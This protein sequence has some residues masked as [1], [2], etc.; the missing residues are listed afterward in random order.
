MRILN[1]AGTGP[2]S[3]LADNEDISYKNSVTRCGSQHQTKGQ[4]AKLQ[5]YTVHDVQ[6]KKY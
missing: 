4:Q 3:L 1:I 5:I 2:K 6:Y